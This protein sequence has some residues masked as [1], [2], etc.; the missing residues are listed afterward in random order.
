M[1]NSADKIIVGT[2]QFGLDYGVSNTKGKTEECEV[3]RILDYLGYSGVK[4]LDTAP[5]YGDS[6]RIISNYLKNNNVFKVNTKISSINN[7]DIKSIIKEVH[8]SLELFNGNIS[9]L[10]F[11]DVN[12]FTNKNYDKVIEEVE[13]LKRKGYINKVGVSIYDENQLDNVINKMDV[14]VVQVPFNIYDQRLIGSK[15]II[16]LSCR[17]TE[18]HARSIFLQGLILMELEHI[19]SKLS[20]MKT[21]QESLI[22]YSRELNKSVYELCLSWVFQQNWI[23]KI[24]V[25]LNDLSQ[26]KKLIKSISGS[27]SKDLDLK[28]YSISEPL[29]INPVNWS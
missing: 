4:Y 27:L 12:D 19:P 2:A 13:C 6:H 26:S 15:R 23:D 28:K 18:I 11:H 3:N 22:L 25:G 24:V 1:N 20:S 7:T 17:G 29:I 9:C 21:Q 8:E 14:D 5:A 10:S 16:E